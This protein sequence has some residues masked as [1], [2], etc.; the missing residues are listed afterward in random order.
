[1]LHESSSASEQRPHL[2]DARAL[3]RDGFLIVRDAIGQPL[4]AALEADLAPV[5]RAAPFSQGLFYGE[6][7][8]RF[9]RL[10]ARSPHAAA[11]ALHDQVIAL[12]NAMVGGESGIQLNLTQAIEIHPGAPVQV[13]H[14][15]HE[16]WPVEKRA[17]QLMMNVMWPLDDFTRENGATRLWPGSHRRD[18]LLLPEEEAVS[19]SAP[20]GSAIIFLGGLL[21][22]GGANRS[23]RPRRGLIFSY[24]RG[25]L[26]PD[27]NPW[28][29]YP[30]EIARGFSAE[31]AALVGY[32]QRFAGLNNFEGRCPSVLLREAE[33][34]FYAFSDDLSAEQIARVKGY[35]EN[36]EQ[37]DAA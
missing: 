2:S 35:Y 19:A 17:E 26:L 16:M 5:F 11:L 31:L 27:E 37:K 36:I 33:Q 24:C 3:E 18:E 13:P 10:L 21:H 22:S 6:T 1:M 14:R 30:P 12:A 9:G 20:R 15:D 25:W 7:T 34:P 32:R 29:A 4:L 8:K 28:L 23:P